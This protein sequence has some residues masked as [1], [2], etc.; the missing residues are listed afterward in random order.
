[1]LTIELFWDALAIGGYSE[2]EQPKI[3]LGIKKLNVEWKPENDCPLAKITCAVHGAGGGVNMTLVPKEF[4]CCKCGKR[5]SLRTEKSYAWLQDNI[6]QT[7][8]NDPVI[9][10]LKDNWKLVDSSSKGDEWIK[11]ISKEGAR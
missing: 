4:A 7:S 6:S 9:W 5:I 10:K 11:S 8:K 2:S 3:S 1:M